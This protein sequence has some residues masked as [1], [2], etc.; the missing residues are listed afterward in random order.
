MLNPQN[1]LVIRPFRHAHTKG[2]ADRELYGLADYLE[3]A[4]ARPTLSDLDH[5]RWERYLGKRAGRLAR[6]RAEW[7]AAAAAAREGA[8]GEGEERGGPGGSGGAA[9]GGEAGRSGGGGEA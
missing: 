6:M 1:G 7:D 5:G 9:G 4:G 3:L 8:E 2:R